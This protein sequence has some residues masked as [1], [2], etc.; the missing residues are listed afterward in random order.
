MTAGLDHVGKGDAVMP[1]QGRLVE[2]PFTPEE[3]R[4][5]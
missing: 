2:R 3:R 5:P 4:V 1:G